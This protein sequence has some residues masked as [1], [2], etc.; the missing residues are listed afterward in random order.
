M[1]YSLDAERHTNGHNE[2]ES[3]TNGDD[4][5]DSGL[6]SSSN[7]STYSSKRRLEERPEECSRTPSRMSTAQSQHDTDIQLPDEQELHLDVTRARPASQAQHDRDIQ[8]PNEQ[9][10]HLD[11]DGEQSAPQSQR[12]AKT[13]LPEPNDSPQEKAQ[14][15]YLPSEILCMVA[16]HLEPCDLVSLG[17]TRKRLQ[18]FSWDSLSILKKEPKQR[19]KLLRALDPDLPDY[20]FCSGCSKF[21]KWEIENVAPFP[22]ITYKAYTNCREANIP[23]FHGIYLA[24]P[25][26]QLALR[27][28]Y[29]KSRAYGCTGETSGDIRHLKDTYD[30]AEHLTWKN[31]LYWSRQDSGLTITLRTLRQ[32]LAQTRIEQHQCRG[33]LMKLDWVD[34]SRTESNLIAQRTIDMKASDHWPLHTL[35]TSWAPAPPPSHLLRPKRRARKGGYQTQNHDAFDPTAGLPGLHWSELPSHRRHRGLETWSAWQWDPTTGK[36]SN[37]HK[38]LKLLG[39]LP[40][41]WWTAP[42]LVCNGQKKTSTMQSTSKQSNVSET[43]NSLGG[44][45]TIWWK[46]SAAV[47]NSQTESTTSQ[48]TPK[49][50]NV[51][52][53]K[54][55][56]RDSIIAWLADLPPPTLE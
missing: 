34:A 17:L 23:L 11:F 53:T 29:Y 33:L 24:W 8:L 42:A 43:R 21:H 1:L 25:S 27:Y 28:L 4:G 48:W 49:Q 32:W 13:Q 6:D 18:D 22:H 41:V 38:N 46:D 54:K 40:R 19:V 55:S 30:T 20:R 15:Q 44:L 50:L 47:C 51:S 12:C 26:T 35:E 7:S 5:Y 52:G 31:Q 9:E 10:L 36:P 16:S 3:A 45:P 37:G 39:D 2:H 14:L 56:S